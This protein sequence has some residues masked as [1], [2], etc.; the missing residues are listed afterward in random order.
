MKRVIISLVAFAV[1]TLGCRQEK[2]SENQT[3]EEAP[4]EEKVMQASTSEVSSE[5]LKGILSSYFSVKDALV[6]TD[7][8]QAKSAIIGSVTS[9]LKVLPLVSSPVREPVISI[10]RL[11]PSSIP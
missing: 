2:K 4:K 1:L 10:I 7:A 5:Q 9:E 8:A 11:F 3:A 6:Q